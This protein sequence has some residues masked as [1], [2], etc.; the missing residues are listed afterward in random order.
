MGVFRVE[1]GASQGVGESHGSVCVEFGA[2]QGV[3]EVERAP[4]RYIEAVCIECYYT[5]DP[6]ITE[7]SGIPPTVARTRYAI[8]IYM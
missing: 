4:S 1:F 5:N 8:N 2:S 3:G 6:Y 7:Q